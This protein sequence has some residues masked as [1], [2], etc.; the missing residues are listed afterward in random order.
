MTEIK[1]VSPPEGGISLYGLR[2]R[3]GEFRGSAIEPFSDKIIRQCSAFGASLFQAAPRGSPLKSLGFFLRRANLEELRAEFNRTCPRGVVYGPRGVVFLIPPT[4]VPS[5]MAY[6]WLFSAI[7]G[8]ITIVRVPGRD[9]SD[10][11]TILSCLNHAFSESASRSFFLKYDYDDEVTDA[12]SQLCDLRVIWGGDETVHRLRT[13]SLPAGARDLTFPDRYSLAAVSAEQYLRL[14]DADRESLV[15]AAYRDLYT[16]DQAACSSPRLIVWV[17]LDRFCEEAS[18]DFYQRLSS[19]AA[20]RYHCELSSVMSKKVFVC[21]AIL[22]QGVRSQ[23]F[24]SSELT[25]IR[26]DQLDK[27]NRQ[28]CGGGLLFEFFTKNLDAISSFISRR[29]QTLSYFGFNPPEL[30]SFARGVAG[31]GLDRIVPIGQALNFSHLWDG[32]DLLQEFVR[33]IHVVP[34]PAGL[35][36]PAAA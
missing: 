22:A 1:L 3:I 35:S 30:A 26:T 31:C 12:L 2:D 6:S 8:N 18:A 29:D 13:S 33:R 11:D 27:I 36:E 24:C 9:S 10:A 5:L 14:N 20:S 19:H 25:V 28:H 21:E 32:Y 4:N 23:T 15:T 7:A 34:A 16:F 17:G